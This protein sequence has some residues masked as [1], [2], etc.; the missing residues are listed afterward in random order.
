MTRLAVT[1]VIPT[2][3]RVQFLDKALRSAVAECEPGDE[4]IVV[5][6]GSTDGT[7]ALVRACGPPVKYMSTPHAGAGA[8]R[9][10]GVRAAGGDLI[11]LLDSDDEW[12]PGKLSWQRAVMEQFPEL[13]F[14]FSDFSVI[15]RTGERSGHGLDGWKSHAL[16]PWDTILGEGLPSES[17]P[18]MPVSAPSFGLHV[19]SLYEKYIWGWCVFTATVVIR[20]EAAGDSLR[21]AEDLPTFEDT[22]CYA[23]MAGRGP[24]GF[25]DCDTA[26]QRNH[27]SGRLVDAD[28]L[29]NAATAV[30]LTARVWGSDAQYLG[31]H[32]DDY[33][34]V[35]DMLRGDLVRHLLGT[36]RQREARAELARCH[37]PSPLYRLLTFIPGRLMAAIAG[38]RRG[39]YSRQGSR[40]A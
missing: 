3:N 20:R 34:A 8:A 39:R 13:V 21:F 25:M 15:S 11:A 40:S 29:T 12:I 10:A 36:G 1:C 38:W 19:G 23:R 14:V 5:D 7:E 35:M 6:D 24:V 27:G 4:V 30:K 26:W 37:H 17:I 18:G 33:E 28:A 32:R 16:R 9:N 2:Y 22:E 31:S